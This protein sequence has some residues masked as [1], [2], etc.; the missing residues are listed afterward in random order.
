MIIF[1]NVLPWFWYVLVFWSWSHEVSHITHGGQ[2]EWWY[3][4]LNVLASGGFRWLVACVTGTLRVARI[5]SHAP[6]NLPGW[7]AASGAH[8]SRFRPRMRDVEAPCGHPKWITKLNP[9][10]LVSGGEYYGIRQP[11]YNHL[12]S[13]SWSMSM[14]CPRFLGLQSLQFSSFRRR[15]QCLG[16][17]RKPMGFRVPKVKDT[18]GIWLTTGGE[19]LVIPPRFCFTR[20]KKQVC[21]GMSGNRVR[22]VLCQASGKLWDCTLINHQCVLVLPKNV[23]YQT[24]QSVST[25][26]PVVRR[27]T[28]AK[29]RGSS[30][31][32]THQLHS[33]EMW[34]IRSRLDQIL[35]RNMPETSRGWHKRWVVLKSKHEKF[36]PAILLTN[37]HLYIAERRTHMDRK[38]LHRC[39]SPASHFR[40]CLRWK[41]VMF[42]G[43]TIKVSQDINDLIWS[44]GDIYI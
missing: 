12:L 22:L 19:W 8:G 26:S 29:K 21:H 15:I 27:S 41:R 17:C 33:P 37:I 9:G 44:D 24:Q 13:L 7:E 20:N 25:T 16:S 14:F 11:S 2:R 23:R 5:D 34:P 4:R 10:Y 35:G 36:Q 6:H 42:L 28:A 31:E 32:C 1:T 3:S 38:R 30:A 43:K 39:L 18:C 40:T